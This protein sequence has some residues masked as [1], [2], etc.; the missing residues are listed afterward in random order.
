MVQTCRSGGP[1]PR[2]PRRAWLCRR[3]EEPSKR[4]GL[5]IPQDPEEGTISVLRAPGWPAGARGTL[6]RPHLL[7]AP[8][9]HPL[10]GWR[11]KLSLALSARGSQW[12]RG[13][14]LLGPAVPMRMPLAVPVTDGHSLTWDRGAVP[15]HSAHEE[16]VPPN[17][18][19]LSQH[20]GGLASA[21]GPGP[22]VAGG[23]RGSGHTLGPCPH[24]RRGLR[25]ARG[26]P[27]V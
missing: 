5:P 8:A 20:I 15:P 27:G 21:A 12:L 11:P 18:T 10:K 16:E 2:S 4:P 1:L 22:A 6:N 14:G 23:S 17:Q 7:P 25:R 24:P 13:P 3:G 9:G 26:G 19:G